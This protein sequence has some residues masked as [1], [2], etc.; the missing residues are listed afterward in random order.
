MNFLLGIESI[1]RLINWFVGSPLVAAVMAGLIQDFKEEGEEI[2]K[3]ALDAIKEVMDKDLKE[4]E[5]FAIVYQKVREQLPR[6]SESLVN[7]SIEVALRFYKR[8]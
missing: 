2:L 8:A 1:R 3:V 5:R 4:K 7:T 6:A